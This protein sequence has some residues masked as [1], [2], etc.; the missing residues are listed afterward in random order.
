MLDRN[1]NFLL[2]LLI[3]LFIFSC[4]KNQNLETSPEETLELSEFI[5]EISL[6]S[7]CESIR[8]PAGSTNALAQAI[9]EIC[10]GGKIYLEPGLH[11]ETEPLI[12]TKTIKLIGLEEAILRIQA[13]ALQLGDSSTLL[14]MTPALHVLDASRTL[15]QNLTMEPLNEN[16][17]AAIV[18]ENSDACGIMKNNISGF[19]SNILIEKS[20]R[21]VIMKNTIVSR[22]PWAVSM[23][24]VAFGILNVN[25]RS[26]YIAKNDISGALWAIFVSDFWGKIENNDLHDNNF[27]VNVCGFRAAYTLPNGTIPAKEESAKGWKVRNNTISDNMNTG[28][29]VIDGSNRNTIKN[30]DLFGNGMQDIELTTTTMRNGFVAEASFENKVKAGSYSTITIKDCGN[31]NEIDGGILI[32][33]SVSVCN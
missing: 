28:I 2:L 4:T 6:R 1:Q 8:I 9:A 13:P 24:P 31:D 20:D 30:N 5:P 32:D 11:T 3:S 14:A 10:E 18:L 26:T 15:I 33:T 27:G 25:G 19:Q 23:Q 7:D 12:I 22:M 17:G 16:G 29:L 21:V